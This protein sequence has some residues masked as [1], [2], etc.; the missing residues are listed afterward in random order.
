MEAAKSS[1]R[2]AISSPALPTMKAYNQPQFSAS[3]ELTVNFASLY[4]TLKSIHALLMSSAFILSVVSE[5]LLLSGAYLQS[6]PKLYKWS[7]RLRKLSS[8]LA[9]LGLGFGVATALSAGWS[10]LTPWLV[11]AYLL[12]ALTFVIGGKFVMPWEKRV[13]ALIARPEGAS[14]TE[15]QTLLRERG[16]IVA[17]WAVVLVL[18]GILLVMRLKPSF[19]NLLSV[20]SV[21]TITQVE[22][23][24]VRPNS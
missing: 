21:D 10:L 8:P 16:A 11:L 20:A 2:R 18:V 3:E 13:E 1:L 12:I 22:E 6:A 19:N 15:L 24:S 7:H 23:V 9:L 4:P 17:R 14:V 5:I